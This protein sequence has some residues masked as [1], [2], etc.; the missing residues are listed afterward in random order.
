M[1]IEHS[2]VVRIGT[3]DYRLASDD[4]FLSQ[5]G[6][7]FEP[8]TVHL[9]D[10]LVSKDFHVLDVGAN[11]GCTSILFGELASRVASFEPSP[12]TFRLLEKNIAQSGLNN[13][14]L[15][16][17]ALGARTES[18]ELTFAPNNRAGGFVS[19]R[20]KPARDR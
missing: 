10:C 13:I 17:Y 15:Y 18:S 19:N 2:H 8:E 20:P 16:N 6:D 3:K 14:E 5:M 4:D 1:P 7:Q 9:F 12:T 11:I